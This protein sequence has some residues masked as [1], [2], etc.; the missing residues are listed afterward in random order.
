MYIQP[1]PDILATLRW[2]RQYYEMQEYMFD[3][4]FNVI[5]GSNR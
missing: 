5:A 3:D 1:Q 2:E 4:C